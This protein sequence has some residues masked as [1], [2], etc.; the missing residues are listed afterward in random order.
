MNKNPVPFP[1]K[2]GKGQ[3][4]FLVNRF[5][6]IVLAIYLS[7]IGFDNRKRIKLGADF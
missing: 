6:S 4:F 3:K 5:L 1:A 7:L 2:N